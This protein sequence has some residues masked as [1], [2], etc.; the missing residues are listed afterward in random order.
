MRPS[1]SLRACGPRFDVHQFSENPERSRGA[2]KPVQSAMQFPT[3]LLLGFCFLSG[4]AAA[5]NAC[6]LP[7][8]IRPFT[9]EQLRN[10]A[11]PPQ[12]RYAVD[13]YLLSLSWSP[14]F[15]ADARPSGDSRF[16]CD[17]NRFAFVVHGL[18]PNS[19]LAPTVADQPAYCREA[20]PISVA[21]HKA[22]L[23]T[24]PG[25][26]LM[27]HEWQK[28]G[29]CAFATPDAYFGKIAELRAKLRLPDFNV[30]ADRPVTAGIIRD[31]FVKANPQLPRTSIMVDVDRKSRLNEV[32]LCLD[33]RFAYARCQ[34][35]GAP[36][37]I[38][39]RIIRTGE[40]AER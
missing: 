40:R 38:R 23:C 5:Q 22:H 30:V 12:R 20:T 16:Q 26:K 29:V 28:H 11:E 7:D 9:A 19:S 21:T 32:R 27:T 1:T 35:A 17:Q 36:D 34:R 10:R 25:V 37:P 31:A 2:S 14:S 33:A 24:V 13:S 4:T 39:V 8:E 18:W 15:C 3:L 6:T